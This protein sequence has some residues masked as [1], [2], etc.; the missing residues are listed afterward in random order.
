ML[1]NEDFNSAE[2]PDK[3][4]KDGPLS[5]K[6]PKSIPLTE[7]QIQ[8]RY[9]AAIKAVQ[10]DRREYAMN[11]AFLEGK[12]WIKW[13]ETSKAY[14][15]WKRPGGRTQFTV[16][17][18][19]NLV[20]TYM[21]KITRAELAFNVQAKTADDYAIQGALVAE[22]LVEYKHDECDWEDK[23]QDLI[24]AAIKGGT[25]AL[26]IDWDATAV[27]YG[28]INTGDSRERV[29]NIMEFALE[30]GSRSP[31]EARYF[32]TGLVVPVEQAQAMYKLE[33]APQEAYKTGGPYAAGLFSGDMDQQPV[34]GALVV[35]YYERPN[36]L[37]PEGAVA[38]LVNGKMAWGPKP[39]PFPFKHLNIKLVR[40]TIIDG[41]WNGTT[42]LSKARSVQ[43]QYNFVHSNIQ[44]HIKKV[45]T[46]KLA[47]PYGASEVFDQMDDDPANPIRYPDGS[48]PPH[49]M[50]PPAMPGYIINQLDR[51]EKDMEDIMGIHDASQGIAPA[52]IESGTGVRE[53]IEQDASAATMVGKRVAWAFEDIASM[54]LE[55][56]AKNVKETR[57]AT[58]YGDDGKIAESVKWTGKTLAGQTCV[59]VPDDA[60]IPHSKAAMQQIAM[61]LAKMGM[62]PPGQEGLTMM[63]EIAEVPTRESSMW[64]INPDE[65]R[66][67]YDISRIMQ[68]ETV[69]PPEQIN[70]AIALKV[71]TR[72]RLSP[73]Y[74]TLTPEIQQDFNNYAM[75]LQRMGEEQ[76]GEM[77]NRASISPAL[78]AAPTANAAAPL[79]AEMTGINPNQP[80]MLPPEL[81]SEAEATPVAQQ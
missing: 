42:R 8:K 55:L 47:A 39:W 61:E 38:V 13:V 78:A 36:Y 9:D 12:Q 81:S 35:T 10:P 4:P 53:I 26:I 19:D 65:A 49:W 32:V 64:Y 45:G 71:C 52:N 24:L 5:H 59:K 58:V 43:I 34:K 31:E 48:Q 74:D 56:Y 23:R 60:I 37:R 80:A 11:H 33:H 79:P 20:T 62:L 18:L 72:Y 75:M 51:L 73:R 22:A 50:T 40:E 15:P 69:I 14:V 27:S 30:P 46:A 17:K 41:R 54:G 1:S 66:A 29:L 76:A 3:T 2:T 25:S 77:V 68:G 70:I 16:N 6:A 63:L 28:G 21:S 44:D 57:T 7:D 67:R